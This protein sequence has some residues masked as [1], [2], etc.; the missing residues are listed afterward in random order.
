MKSSDTLSRLAF[1]AVLLACCCTAT[2]GEDWPQWRGPNRNGISDETGWLIQWPPVEQWRFSLGEGYSS[3]VV[4]DGRLYTMGWS[5][6]RD[7]VFCLDATT[8]TQ[9]WA[10]AY[11]CADVGDDN[12]SGTRCTPTVEGDRLYTCSQR[13]HF[14][15]LDRLTGAVLWE[16][17]LSEVNRNGNWGYAS[18]PL[19]EGDLI[20]LCAASGKGTAIDKNHPHSIVWSNPGTQVAQFSSPIAF[21]WNSQRLVALTSRDGLEVLNPLNGSILWSHSWPDGYLISDPIVHDGNKLFLTTAYGRGGAQIQLNADGTTTKLWSNYSLDVH[22]GVPVLVGDY[23]YGFDGKLGGDRYLRCI[24]A[25]DGST[26]WSERL[27]GFGAGSVTSADGKIIVM[28]V[29]GQVTVVKASPTGFDTEGRTAIDAG[30]DPNW[31]T[32]PTLANGDLYLRSQAGTLVSYR[33]G[34]PP[35]PEMDLERNGIPIAANA[36]DTVAATSPGTPKN[37]TFDV[38]NTGTIDLTVGYSRFMISGLANCGVSVQ[39]Y[40]AASVA[41]DSATALVVDVTPDAPGRWQFTATLTSNDGD[42][43]N[44]RWT[45]EGVAMDDGDGDGML[46][47][48]EITH[49][50]GTNAPPLGDADG[51]GFLNI[52]EHDAGT[53]PTNAASLLVATGATPGAG[54]LVMEWQSVSGKHYAIRRWM[55]LAGLSDVV[56]SNIPASPPVNRHTNDANAARG[57]YRVELD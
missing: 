22:V 36:T 21:T 9:V 13:G 26:K 16:K 25:R 6:S 4:K 53:D 7:T 49:F 40:P 41:P 48:W 15:C 43:S 37:L 55:D 38:L 31:W 46:D 3:V 12:Y 51:D 18:S 42:E 54:G 2:R 57:Y 24:D 27:T 28:G 33:V 39:Q 30:S 44:Y 10:H 20:I 35:A 19:V 50:G 11:T 1:S 17:K 14:Y 52:Y 45:T 32:V 56:V 34:A 8:G 5:S 47:T 29:R 23:M